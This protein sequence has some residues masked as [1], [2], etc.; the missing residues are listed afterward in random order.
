MLYKSL[1]YIPQTPS[2]GIFLQLIFYPSLECECYKARD[3]LILDKIKA[4]AF[5]KIKV[6]ISQI[7]VLLSLLVVA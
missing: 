3:F 6:G 1:R 2:P 5:S 7:V 4:K